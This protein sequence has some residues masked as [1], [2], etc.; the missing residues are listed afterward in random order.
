MFKEKNPIMTYAARSK[1]FSLLKVSAS[2][3][4]FTEL[5][6]QIFAKGG[7]V[8]GAG[9][10]SSSMTVAHKCAENME[11]LSEMRGSK[12]AQSSMTGVYS[13]VRAL[14]KEGRIVLFT[15]MPCQVAAMRKCFG[16][17]PNL[18][19]CGIMCHSMSEPRVWKKYISE[20]ERK[21]QSRVT[22]VSFRDERNGWRKSTMVVRFQDST[23]DIAENLYANVYARAYFSGYAT[24]QCCLSCQFRSGRC[25]ADL[26]IGDFWGVE[27]HKPELDDGK[28][29]S[30]VLL[31]TDVGRRLFDLCDIEKYELTYQQVL[32]KNPFLETSIKPNLE[33]RARFWKVYEK[34]DITGAVKYAAEGPMWVRVLRFA[35]RLPRRVVGKSLRIVGLRK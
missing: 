3:G 18:V 25:A 19:L 35:Y 11:Q 23:K 2:G 1:D 4:M 30:A 26:I 16:W 29:V 28:G 15:G 27:D 14:L 7:V 12:Y 21:F 9:W 6:K 24:K 22:A 13:S 8:F 17:N 33:Q 20:L 5:A 32:A 31:F 34:M 10:D